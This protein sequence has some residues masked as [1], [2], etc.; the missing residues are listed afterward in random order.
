MGITEYFVT[1]PGQYVLSLFVDLKLAFEE[2]DF[3]S[4][5]FL[6]FLINS[7]TGLI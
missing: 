1:F 4:I 7:G 5:T 2:H 6:I 3:F